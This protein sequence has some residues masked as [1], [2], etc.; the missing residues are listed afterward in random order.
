METLLAVLEQEPTSPRQWNAGVP[1]DL[2]TI[3]LKCL[4]KEPARRYGSAQELA[5][6]LQRYLNGEPILAR[7]ITRVQRAARWVARKPAAAGAL[8]FA[9]L[10][11]VSLLLGVAFEWVWL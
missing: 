6:E 5:E 10:M 3:C 4:A 8:A 1:L 2:N 7:P 9:V 11:T